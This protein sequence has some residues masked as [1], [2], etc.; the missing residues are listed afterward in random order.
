ML[1]EQGIYD[2][3]CGADLHSFYTWWS[4]YISP[5]S[6]LLNRSFHTMVLWSSAGHYGV[7][8]ILTAITFFNSLTIL[9]SSNTLKPEREAFGNYAIHVLCGASDLCLPYDLT[10]AGRI[11][12]TRSSPSVSIEWL[13]ST[14]PCIFRI[15][16]KNIKKTLKPLLHIYHCYF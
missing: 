4:P 3:Q 10:K 6:D 2:Y 7:C 11:E 5:P 12:Q 8:K 13:T 16:N 15:K 9:D 1:A 14:C